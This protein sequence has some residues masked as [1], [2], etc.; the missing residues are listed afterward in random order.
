MPVLA[1]CQEEDPL[2]CLVVSDP[3]VPALEINDV[4]LSLSCE[5]AVLQVV[6]DMTVCRGE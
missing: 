1:V 5:G 4:L 6:L 3:F 2:E